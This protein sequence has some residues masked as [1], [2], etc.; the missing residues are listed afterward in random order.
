MEYINAFYSLSS[1]RTIG[2]SSE[3]PISMVDVSAY[4]QMYPTEDI[5]RFMHL[6]GQMDAEYMTTKYGN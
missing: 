1:K 6:I 2:F 4:L 3:N 5:D